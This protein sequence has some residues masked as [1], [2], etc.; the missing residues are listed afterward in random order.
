MGNV[1]PRRHI[2]LKKKIQV[3]SIEYLPMN[4]RPRTPRIPKTIHTIVLYDIVPD[5]QLELTGMTL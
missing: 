5:C 2:L 4:G 1:V 3:P